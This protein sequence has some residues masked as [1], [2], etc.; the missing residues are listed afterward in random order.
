[1]LGRDIRQGP[2]HP[3]AVFVISAMNFFSFFVRRISEP[4]QNARSEWVH[5]HILFCMSIIVLWSSILFASNAF[6]WLQM[7]KLS[8]KDI[9]SWEEMPA[10]IKSIYVQ[11][12]FPFFDPQTTS[13]T[14]IWHLIVATCS[15]IWSC[16]WYIFVDNCLGA[17][18]WQMEFC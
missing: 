9:Y 11:I 5:F 10:P 7:L 16:I 8:S 2:L 4:W 18:I 13:M 3:H 6:L 12:P 15:S 1:M 17:K 14:T